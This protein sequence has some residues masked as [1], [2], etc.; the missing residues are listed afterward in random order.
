MGMVGLLWVVAAQAAEPELVVRGHRT[1]VAG[2][3]TT[4]VGAG[5]LSYGT[6]RMMTDWEQPSGVAPGGGGSVMLGMA[7]VTVGPLMLSVS[8]VRN[9][10]RL[11]AM[12]ASHGR[13]AGWV[14]LAS[15]TATALVPG[16]ARDSNEVV[17]TA[18]TLA[19]LGGLGAS[20]G[21]HVQNARAARRM[22]V[23]DGGRAGATVW[24]SAGGVGVAGWF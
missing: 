20:S 11:Q 22:G 15:L 10:G 2:L 17:L 8:S 12:D 16:A 3:V 18:M 24:M 4:G 6:H 21:Q 23:L 1:G 7:G 13:A 14:G 19:Y 9:G 5:L